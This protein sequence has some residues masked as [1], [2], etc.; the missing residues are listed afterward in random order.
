MSLWQETDFQKAEWL[1]ALLQQ[2]WPSLSRRTETAV[3]CSLQPLLDKFG[4]HGRALGMP[5]SCAFSLRAANLGSKSPRVRGV[6]V[7]SR[8]STGAGLSLE[9][10]MKWSGDQLFLLQMSAVD[11]FL[12]PLDVSLSDVLVS[13]V[14]VLR[15][16]PDCSYVALCLAEQPSIDFALKLANFDVTNIGMSSG[17]VVPEAELTVMKAAE[18]A[19]RR[20]IA[21]TMLSPKEVLIPLLAAAR[22]EDAK[23][24][25]RGA[26]E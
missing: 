18:F 7:L 12:P 26:A 19:I 20:I 4:S 11:G 6:R 17:G 13:A 10:D 23:S 9:I 22:G 15:L 8:S 14:L 16:P 24:G 3:K 25:V 21:A 2:C 5:Y 1:N